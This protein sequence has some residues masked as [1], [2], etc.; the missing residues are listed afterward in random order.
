MAKRTQEAIACFDELE[1][2]VHLA[3]GALRIT[4]P[5]GTFN[6]TSQ[7]RADLQ[8]AKTWIQTHLPSGWS[9][10]KRALDDDSLLTFLAELEAAL[11]SISVQAAAPED[12]TYVLVTLAQLWEGQAQR[13]YRA[14][15]IRIPA[16]ILQQ[17]QSRCSNLP[18]V[19]QQLFLILDQLHRASSGIESINSR[20][21]LY[22]YT[23]RR[24]SADFANLIAVWH[25][26]SPFEDGKRAGQSPAQI[27]HIPLPTHD[28]LRLFNVA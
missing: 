4:T 28:L 6:S 22:R 13:R 12:R 3:F 5:Y 19:Q 24:F 1:A 18:D 8:F 25:N 17:L 20:V 9:R 10:V 14:H 11:P 21:G 7:A 2:A 23:K 27:L 26:L 16:P 15:P